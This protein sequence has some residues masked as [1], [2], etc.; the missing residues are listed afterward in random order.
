M[1]TGFAG[2]FPAKWKPV[3]RKKRSHFQ[4]ARILIAKPGTTFAEYPPKPVF[5]ISRFSSL[6]LTLVNHMETKP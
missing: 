2:A 6:P 1:K 4:D 5:F 3:C